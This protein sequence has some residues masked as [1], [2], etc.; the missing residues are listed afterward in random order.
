MDRLTLDQAGARRGEL[1]RH[2]IQMGGDTVTIENI[3]TLSIV[4]ERFEPYKTPR[5]QGALGVWIGL[6]ILSALTFI[7]S[8]AIWTA[9][10]GSWFGITALV[11]LL[12]FLL[13]GAS[14]WFG[15]RLALAIRKVETFYRLRIG[16]SDGRQIDL[17]DDSEA[18]L[19]QIRNAIRAKIDDGDA[20]LVGTYDLDADTVSLTRGGQPIAES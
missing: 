20:D 6:G 4:S 7:V 11:V 12:S 8:L 2:S 1:F 3:A 15:G 19:T 9:S 17:V 5:N 16:A 10:D 14:I 13:T 18:V